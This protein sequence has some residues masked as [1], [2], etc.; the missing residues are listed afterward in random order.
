[1]AVDRVARHA[2]CGCYIQD[3]T[4]THNNEGKTNTLW[5]MLYSVYAVLG[6]CCTQCRLYLVHAVLGVCCT[7]GMLYLGYAVLGACCTQL[8]LAT[9]RHSWV[10]FGSGSNPEPNR[11]NSFPHKTRASKVNISCSN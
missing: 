1:M 9:G 5:R 3:T 11:C 6:V 2:G 8:V 10:G 4:R 7:W